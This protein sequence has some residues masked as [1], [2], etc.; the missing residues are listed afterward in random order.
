[1]HFAVFINP[2]I[3]FSYEISNCVVSLLLRFYCIQPLAFFP[4]FLLFH[5]T[6]TS[7]FTRFDVRRPDRR[8][9]VMIFTSTLTIYE[10]IIE[11]GSVITV[12]FG[13][14][15]IGIPGSFS[16]LDTR[17]IHTKIRDQTKKAEKVVNDITIA[18]TTAPKQLNPCWK[19]LRGH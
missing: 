15:V 4:L 16:S 9:V 6:F 7:P 5:R 18:T 11:V 1:M 10:L 13:L 14:F 3:T 2:S 12:W 19:R 17:M 8:G